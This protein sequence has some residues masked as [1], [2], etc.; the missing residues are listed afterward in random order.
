MS[1]EPSE[2]DPYLKEIDSAS[3]QQKQKAIQLLMRPSV[4]LKA[5]VAHFPML[6]SA[7]S[8]YSARNY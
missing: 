2:A 1:I 4:G 6:Q 7:L 5:M 8:K 3:M